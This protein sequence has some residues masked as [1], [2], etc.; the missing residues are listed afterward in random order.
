MKNGHKNP[1]SLWNVL[2]FRLTIIDVAS[3]ILHDH[4]QCSPAT[5]LLRYYRN[6]YMERSPSEANSRLVNEKIPPLIKP[7][8]SSPFWQLSVTGPLVRQMEKIRKHTHCFCNSAILPATPTSPRGLFSSGLLTKISQ[9]FPISPMRV[10]CSAHIFL[11]V[12]ILITITVI[13][14][15][16]FLELNNIKVT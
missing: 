5:L 16:T 2:S 4:T 8:V 14:W 12:I 7:E 13:I 15:T 3:T 6:L 1:C 10:T 11:D 9:A